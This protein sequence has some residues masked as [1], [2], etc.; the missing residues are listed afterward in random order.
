[1]LPIKILQKSGYFTEFQLKQDEVLFDEGDIDQN[2]Y[3]ILSGKVSI[4]KYTTQER[5]ETK[6]LAELGSNEIFGEGA[7]N[8]D[9]KK[10]I[11]I[12]ATENTIL[13]S[14]NAQEGLDTFTQEYPHEGMNILKYIIYTANKRLLNANNLITANYKVSQ[15]IL[16][17]K[18]VN[19]KSIFELFDKLESIL[20]I[21]YSIF[22]EKNS[23]MENYLTLKYD[24][25]EKSKLQNSVIEITEN[26]LSLLE[27]KIYNTCSYI[28]SLSIG[29]EKLGYL[30]YFR[31]DKDFNDNDKK[32]FSSITTG[33]S[34]L[35]KEKII[36]EEERDR[37]YMEG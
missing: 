30:I 15:E 9:R 13:L 12:K 24:S 25:R 23:V 3:I 22:L 26:K 28:Q 21:D 14:I 18:E 2:I 8:S 19:N 6:I 10:Q 5:T 27:L 4:E 31:K 1:M 33:I 32:I 11:K 29:D 36:Q 37:E 7:L 17:I 34:G 35:I 20:D 16:N